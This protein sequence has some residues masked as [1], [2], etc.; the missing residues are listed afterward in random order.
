MKT[1]WTFPL[2]TML[3]SFR[4]GAAPAPETEEPST[5]EGAAVTV[6]APSTTEV[7]AADV[8]GELGEQVVSR[9]N[10]A[11][12]VEFEI[13]YNPSKA[14][15]PYDY[16]A[17]CPSSPFY[18]KPNQFRTQEDAEWYVKEVAHGSSSEAAAAA[19]TSAALPTTPAT[20][21][22]ADYT[23]FEPAA[24]QGATYRRV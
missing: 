5:G 6:T 9:V 20:T 7:S 10:S 1:P 18:D 15:Y 21:T 16:G 4:Q 2:L 22:D 24:R 11:A 13:V 19:S 14:T 8:P 17:I 12:G 3:R 23:P